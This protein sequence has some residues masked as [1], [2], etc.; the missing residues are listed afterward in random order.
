LKAFAPGASGLLG[1]FHVGS[2]DPG[3][4]DI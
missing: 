2:E 1:G 4:G 3:S